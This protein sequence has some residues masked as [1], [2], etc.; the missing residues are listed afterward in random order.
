MPCCTRQCGARHHLVLQ[1]RARNLPASTAR[2]SHQ[3]QRLAERMCGIYAVISQ[4]APEK[5][6]GDLETCLRSRGPDHIG[7][8]TISAEDDDSPLYIALTSTVLA[9]RGDHTTVQPL[10]DSSSGSALCWNGEAWRIQGQPV[11]GNDGEVVLSKLSA[12]SAGGQ[13]A[14]L[15]TLRAIE[16]PFAFVFVD[17]PSKML[18]YGRDRLGRRSLLVKPDSPFQLSSIPDTSSAGW[19]EV[20]ADGCYSIPLTSNSFASAVEPVRHDWDSNQELVSEKME[21]PQT[22]ANYSDIGTRSL[23]CK[24]TRRVERYGKYISCRREAEESSPP[25]AAIPCTRCTYTTRSRRIAGPRSCP[26]LRGPRLHCPGSFNRRTAPKRSTNRS[27]ERC[28]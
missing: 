3:L 13:E 7:S 12:A 21:Y 8:L 6:T 1:R 11:S 16:G 18:Y 23:Q 9:L 4:N 26:V 5:I 28:F 2:F 27:F 14:I 24:H 15:D 22:L 19:L 10:L 17:K 20:E 25:I